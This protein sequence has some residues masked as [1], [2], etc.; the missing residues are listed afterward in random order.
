MALLPPVA[1]GPGSRTMHNHD[2]II[3]KEFRGAMRVIYD[4]RAKQCLAR[5]EE[6]NF[7][8]QSV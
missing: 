8:I 1:L 7:E 6:E 5:G 3:N 2:F 4:S